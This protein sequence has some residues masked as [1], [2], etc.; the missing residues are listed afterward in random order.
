[1]IKKPQFYTE[2]LNGDKTKERVITKEDFDLWFNDLLK[3]AVEVYGNKNGAQWFVTKG[4]HVRE[5]HKAL[6]IN[7]EPI[8]QESCAD[9]L[10]DLV[11]RFHPDDYSGTDEDVFKIIKR[12]KAALKREEKSE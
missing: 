10:K 11:H 12:A 9:V 8:R 1:M 6:L 2:L 7:I 5:E 3:D 4:R